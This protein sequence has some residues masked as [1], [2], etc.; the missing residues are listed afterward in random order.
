MSCLYHKTHNS[1]IFCHISAGLFTIYYELTISENA[2]FRSS[3]V[4]LSER[5][6]SP[7]LNYTHI[8]LPDFMS[9]ISTIHA[10]Y[11]L[12]AITI[13]VSCRSSFLL[14]ITATIQLPG[15]TLQQSLIT[16]S[17]L[18]KTTSITRRTNLVYIILYEHLI[19]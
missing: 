17:N 10:I 8:L 12:L 18:T 14:Y 7:F 19:N 2:L 4:R 1:A 16:R 5:F 13:R 15:L 11:I 3:F 6:W 9:S